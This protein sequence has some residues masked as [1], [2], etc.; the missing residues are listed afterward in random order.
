[1]KIGPLYQESPLLDD[2]LLQESTV[3]SDIEVGMFKA[4]TAHCK[5]LQ[6][7]YS[8]W[9]CY[10]CHCNLAMIFTGNDSAHDIQ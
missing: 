1:M 8:H 3:F 6:P 7:V 9:L 2:T 10:G 4:N 5:Y